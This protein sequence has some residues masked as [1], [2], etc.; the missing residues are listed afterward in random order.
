MSDVVLTSA[1]RTNLLSLQNTQRLIDNTQL[2][3]ATGLK[4]NSALDSPQN[5]FA[6]QSL[7][8][9]ASDLGRL[10]DGISQSIRTIEAADNGITALTTLVEQASSIATSARDAISGSEQVAG[11]TGN[12]D[13]SGVEDLVGDISDI[14]TGDDL[15]FTFTD[16][17]GDAVVFTTPGTDNSVE[18]LTGETIDD[19]V[20]NINGIRDEDGNKVVKAEL[21]DNGFLKLTSL[22]GGDL[23]IDTTGTGDKAV[24][25]GIGFGDLG[26]DEY[27]DGI[28]G[29]PDNFAVTIS[30]T[31]TIQ[32]NVFYDSNG[33]IA[34]ASDN[35]TALFESDG[36]T[37]YTFTGTSGEDDLVVLST[38]NG[39]FVELG[40]IADLSIQGTVDA[41]NDD[42]TLNEL[43]RA[44]YDSTTGQISIVALSA[45][46]QSIQIGAKDTGDN[47]SAAAVD[48]G[49]GTTASL[50]AADVAGDNVTS[51]SIRFSQSA[52]DLAQFEGDFNN[53]REQIDALVSDAGYR[54]TNLLNGDDLQTFFNED[55]DSSLTSQG[56]TF[57]A[58]GLGIN[59][60][61]F[62]RISTIDAAL[63]D[64]REALASVRSFGSTIANDLAIIQTR[65]DFTES[66]INTLEAGADD[67]TVAD[68]NEEGAN[69]LALQTRQT[70]GVTSLSLASQSQQAV[71]RLF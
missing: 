33:D 6:A 41:I 7:N 43:I 61:S 35:L 50:T 36:A 15:L 60:A 32:S 16:E 71:L 31:P 22:T 54:G 4:V 46:V 14:D 34:D 65:R 5:F 53:V 11:A 20:N 56:V 59:E 69:L 23:R 17:N 8:N 2:R 44:E 70:L 63:T 49:F 25:Q 37:S 28:E 30:A 19:L 40:R 51:E 42:S 29:T 21:D 45:D 39:S 52:S 55:R 47:T 27:S 18:I 12:K 66:T 62:G 57:T 48:F 67:L 26:V 1:L 3:L 64:V 58:A 24:L 38:N 10:L 68:Q 13:L 9:R